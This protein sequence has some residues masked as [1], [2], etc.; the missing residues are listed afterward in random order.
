MHKTKGRQYSKIW[1]EFKLKR[2]KK[3]SKRKTNRSKVRAKKV[4]LLS[5][6]EEGDVEIAEAGEEVEDGE[7]A[8]PEL[9]QGVKVKVRVKGKLTQQ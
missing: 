5:G 9:E 3:A 8:E 2:L 6:G 4:L 1:T 7:E